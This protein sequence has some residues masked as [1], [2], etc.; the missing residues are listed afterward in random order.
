MRQFLYLMVGRCYVAALIS[1]KGGNPLS[2]RY[3]VAQDDSFPQVGA[4]LPVPRRP[5]MPVLAVLIG[6]VS[7]WMSSHA[8]NP[9]SSGAVRY[10]HYKDT[11]NG[12]ILDA[13]FT[14]RDAVN[15]PRGEIQVSSFL[16]TLLR[17]GQASQV[18]GIA[19]A[20]QCRINPNGKMLGDAGPIQL[21]TPDTNLYV[22]G[23]GFFLS[24]SN[25]VLTLSNQV[26]TR[27]ARSMLRST[28]LA[29]TRT[30]PPELPGET[31]K[32]FS[33]RAAFYF[34]S[35]LLEYVGGVRLVDPQF[36]M[37][38]PRLT[39]QFGSN[40]T[41]ETM[42]ARQ[43]VTYTFPGHGTASGTQS[44][45]FANHGS[46]LLDL[47]GGASDAEWH[48]G[49]QQASARIFTFAPDRH[50]WTAD[51]HV[52]VRWPNSLTNA[53]APQTF[54]DLSNADHVTLTLTSDNRLVDSV[55]ATGN[56]VLTNQADH[57]V[58]TGGKASYRR[59]NDLFV[60]TENPV[61]ANDQVEI[62]GDTL[63]SA[64]NNTV[65]AAQGHAWLKMRV[66][67]GGGGLSG[68]SNQWLQVV[69]DNIALAPDGPET[70][71]ITF[72]GHVHARMLDG[73]ELRDKL[74]AE[75][76]EVYTDAK[77]RPEFLE[78]RGNVFGESAP[79]AAGVKDTISCQVLDGRLSPATGF[80]Q[81]IVAHQNADLESFGSDPRL[82]HNKLCADT[83]TALFSPTTNR[84]D[85]A[86]AD[87]SVD[88]VQT[89]LAKQIHAT[90][91]HAIYSTNP[92][93]QVELFGHPWAQTDKGIVS[94]GTSLRYDFQTGAVN[95]VG[96]YR[97]V[98]PKNTEA[99]PVKSARRAP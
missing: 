6:L 49:G 38:S 32:I 48:N 92:D 3:G 27:V 65:F 29:A 90:A 47:I 93:E 59:T 54:R 43:P 66:S 31:V 63:S 24:E 12:K 13:V 36:E 37:D 69:A 62:H 99:S 85:K 23:V 28:A 42:F 58:A 75:T 98:L 78:A 74:D 72:A 39:I 18:T 20:P 26:E 87:G 16:G 51:D 67:G 17:D 45:Y 95:V 68:S 21:F 80:W 14:G 2:P 60:L 46:A 11:T 64:S 55:D 89:K 57:S 22:Q 8:Q 35:N 5:T 81:E 30:N 79:N 25:M 82:P 7:A 19:Q 50:F 52:R 10:P 76:L 44:H 71:R 53:T 84:L 94:D 1:G 61:W 34:R 56:V 41:V 88:F 86:M 15:L 70:N 91:E 40:R 4:R 33:D 9:P 96:P 83:V 97:I 77:R 73:E